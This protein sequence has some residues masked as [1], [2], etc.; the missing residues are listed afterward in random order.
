MAEIFTYERPEVKLANKV[1]SK[2]ILNDRIDFNGDNDPNLIRVAYKVVEVAQKIGPRVCKLPGNEGTQGFMIGITKNEPNSP[3][4]TVQI[5][6][7]EIADPLYGKDG[8]R[9]KYPE[10]VAKKAKVIQMNPSFISSGEN[11]KLPDKWKEKSSQG[12]EMPDGAIAVGR[13][14]KYII[15]TSAFKNAKMDAAVSLAM[16]AGAGL[17]SFDQAEQLAHDPRMG[18]SKEYMDGVEDILVE[19]VLH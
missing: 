17:V 5:G 8:K 10:F 13:N 12:V 7:V 11:K 6:D 16:A 18:C 2:I 4:L 15:S 14:N 9:G 19:E 3:I 1:Q